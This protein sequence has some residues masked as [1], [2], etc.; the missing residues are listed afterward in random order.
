MKYI[1]LS[2]VEGNTC[3]TLL[4]VCEL[5]LQNRDSLINEKTLESKKLNAQLLI[6]DEIII[7][8]EKHI[9]KI[10]DDLRKEKLRHKFTK[11][12]WSATTI[13]LS[14]II[15]YLFIS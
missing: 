2:I 11:I 12:G 13:I 8:K 9:E 14:S 4:S 3:D 6:K 10:E 15:M 5:K 7:I 1:A